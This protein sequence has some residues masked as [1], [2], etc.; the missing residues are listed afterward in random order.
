MF[1]FKSFRTSMTFR[2]YESVGMQFLFIYSIEKL[3]GHYHSLVILIDK[4]D[5]ILIF[6]HLNSLCLLSY[7]LL[8]RSGTHLLSIKQYE[9][10]LQTEYSYICTLNCDTITQ[11]KEPLLVATVEAQYNHLLQISGATTFK[12]IYFLLFNLLG[13]PDLCTSDQTL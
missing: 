9:S 11:S 10:S 12:F 2:R 13:V 3:Y 1:V 8:I 5:F 4:K 6:N 7:S